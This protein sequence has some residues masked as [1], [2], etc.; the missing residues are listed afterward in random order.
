MSRILDLSRLTLKTP[1]VI[2]VSLTYGDIST[3]S[4]RQ[5]TLCSPWNMQTELEPVFWGRG[6]VLMLDESYLDPVRG[7]RFR[8]KLSTQAVDLNDFGVLNELRRSS[9]QFRFY[10][11]GTDRPYWTVYIPSSLH[12]IRRDTPEVVPMELELLGVEVLSVDETRNLAIVLEPAVSWSGSGPYT[13]TATWTP[14]ITTGR[15][16]IT[17]SDGTNS[18]TASA[19]VANGRLQFDTTSLTSDPATA[20]ITHDTSPYQKEMSI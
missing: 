12:R 3:P 10:P 4:W 15:L 7:F 20:T 9:K 16:Y 6:D 5:Y 1:P 17:V 8:A 18:D 13:I 19:P 11:Y 2:E 14:V